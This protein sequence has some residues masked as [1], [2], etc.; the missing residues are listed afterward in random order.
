VASS[1]VGAGSGRRR[2]HHV[3]WPVVREILVAWLVTL[4]VCALLA[5]VA[6][7]VWRWTT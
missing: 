1:V 4:P 2:M 5:A 7:A 3:H 6:Q